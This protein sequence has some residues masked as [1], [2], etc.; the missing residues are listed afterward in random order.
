MYK[1][2][3]EAGRGS[4]GMGHRAWGTGYGAGRGDMGMRYGL[5]GLDVDYA[6]WTR[7][8]DMAYGI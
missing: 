1:L 5:W 2:S 8:G 7:R 3:Y 4:M 6:Y